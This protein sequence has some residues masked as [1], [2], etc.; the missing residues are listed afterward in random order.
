VRRSLVMKSWSLGVEPCNSAKANPVRYSSKQ[1]RAQRE[2]DGR[3]LSLVRLMVLVLLLCVECASWS[4]YRPIY[5]AGDASATLNPPHLLLTRFN[6]GYAGAS[7]AA[8][9]PTWT[10]ND[11][12]SSFTHRVIVKASIKGLG[13]LNLA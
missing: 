8:Q 7:L 3:I 6:G 2:R 13:N 1:P 10:Q 11:L 9:L 12:F 5:F 4:P